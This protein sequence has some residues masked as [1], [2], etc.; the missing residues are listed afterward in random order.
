[1]RQADESVRGRV[2]VHRRAKAAAS[3]A[4]TAASVDSG[5]RTT[6]FSADPNVKRFD[7]SRVQCRACDKWIPILTDDDAAAIKAWRQHN[8]SC[9][10]QAVTSPGA[11]TSK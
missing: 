5:D 3:T 6:V 4:P 2:H 9:Q 8:E 10:M 7:S 11:S 1:M